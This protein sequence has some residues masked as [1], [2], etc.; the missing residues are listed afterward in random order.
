MR[1]ELEDQHEKEQWNYLRCRAQK[2]LVGHDW[3]E[4]VRLRASV[5]RLAVM[6]LRLP[7]RMLARSGSI[8]TG[9]YFFEVKWDGFRVLVSR[10]ASSRYV[11]VSGS[12]ACW[13]WTRRDGEGDIVWESAAR[14]QSSRAGAPTNGRACSSQLQPG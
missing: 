10:T 9:D 13:S 2:R 3:R 12:A 8:P 11:C 4:H 1:A 7:S 14:A 6:A 5:A